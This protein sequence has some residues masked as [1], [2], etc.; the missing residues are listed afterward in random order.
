MN[1]FDDARSLDLAEIDPLVVSMKKIDQKTTMI[2]ILSG[3]IL[4][5][6]QLLYNKKNPNQLF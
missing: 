4:S 3:L 5:I 6:E 2:Q 1:N